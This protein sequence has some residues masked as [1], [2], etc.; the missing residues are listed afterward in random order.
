MAFYVGQKVVC[1]DS[2]P[3][4]NAHGHIYS[5]PQLRVGH[6]YTV[7]GVLSACVVLLAE[8]DPGRP[9]FDG[10]TSWRFRPVVE[11]NTDISIFEA[12]L[13]PAPQKEPV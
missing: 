13:S 1:V 12:M 11:R 7:S 8:V 5:A 4:R 2:G 6:V 3:V 10:F 9:R